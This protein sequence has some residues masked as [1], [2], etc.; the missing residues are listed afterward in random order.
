MQLSEA[1]NKIT[2]ALS[3]GVQGFCCHLIPN[4]KR[5]AIQKLQLLQFS[6]LQAIAMRFDPI[7]TTAEATV[8]ILPENP[9]NVILFSETFEAALVGQQTWEETKLE[10]L[11]LYFM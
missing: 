4:V 1:L 6:D 7:V 2:F 3:P 8:N 5:T 9:W 10:S 11:R